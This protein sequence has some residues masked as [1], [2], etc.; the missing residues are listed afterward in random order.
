MLR[1]AS[2]HIIDLVNANLQSTYLRRSKRGVGEFMVN[3][4]NN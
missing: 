3:L 4:V 2:R 1:S